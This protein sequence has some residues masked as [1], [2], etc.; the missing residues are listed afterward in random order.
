MLS[1][2]EGSVLFFNF[3]INNL[4]IINKVNKSLA[5]VNENKSTSE[6]LNYIIGGLIII[7]IILVGTTLFSKK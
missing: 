6:N 3:Y 2:G 5:V 4:A 1:K 7:I